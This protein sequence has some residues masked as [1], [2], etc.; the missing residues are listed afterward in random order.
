MAAIDA[1]MTVLGVD[2]DSA[3]VDAL[4]AGNSPIEDVTDTAL[5]AALQRGFDLSLTPEGLGECD[6]VVICVPTPLKD[7]MPDLGAVEA[8]TGWVGR[9]LRPGQLVVLESTTYPGTTEEVVKPL[10]EELSQLKAGTD[11]FLAYA[12]ERIDPGNEEWTFRNTPKVVGGINEASTE[13]AAELFGRVCE[14]VV[15]VSGTRE[16]ELSKLIENTYRQVNIALVN[17]L[18]IASRELGVDIWEAI[19]AAASKPYGFQA[20]YPG[21]GVGGHCIPID[22][23][24]LSYRIRQLGFTFRFVDLAQEINARMPHYVVSR[25]GDMLNRAGKAVN[26]SRILLMG[27]AYKS[28]V[29]DLRETPAA[30]VASRLSDLGA[31]VSFVDPHVDEFVVDGRALNRV[32]DASEAIV[33]ADLVIILT[34]HDALDLEDLDFSGRLVLDT[35]GVTSGSAERL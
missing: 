28:N 8:A 35:R 26:G 1:G 24:Y 23:S 17:E 27:V 10:L 15:V 13:R 18:A 12:P 22:P 11:F 33:A 31:S 16:A 3:K 14:Q 20:F 4:R 32:S 30:D 7:H 9:Y 34:A 25:A 2:I 21:P 6:A 19:R 29:G 5:R